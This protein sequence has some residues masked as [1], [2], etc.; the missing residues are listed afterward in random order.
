MMITKWVSA[1]L[2]LVFMN[3]VSIFAWSETPLVTKGKLLLS[4]DFEIA[5]VA[6]HWRIAIGDFQIDSG[7]FVGNELP[8]DK[9][10]A[11]ARAKTEFKNG[12]VEF[13]F[14]MGTSKTLNF[15]I[16]ERNF[17]GS[18]A[19]HL[20]RVVITKSILRLADD[21][22][23]A[24][25]NDIFAMKDDSTKADER[26][27]LLENRS[28]VFKINLDPMEWHTMRVEILEETMQVSLDGKVVGHL[29]SPGI[30]HERKTD[31]GFTVLGQGVQFDNFQ[32]W[33][34]TAIK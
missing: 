28:A 34:A 15:V 6:P 1:T 9:H 13:S 17:K 19:G 22:E 12:I 25:R 31:V 5:A 32:I 20:C 11:V 29:K 8:Q 27:K 10:G 14:R 26:K 33:E 16:D 4:D 18:H 30:A 7:K 24:M 3:L 23:G 2:A 21:K